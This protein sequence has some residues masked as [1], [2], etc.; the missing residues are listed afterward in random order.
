MS[1]RTGFPP[2]RYRLLFFASLLA[3]THVPTLAR[4]PYPNCSSPG[5]FTVNDTDIK[6]QT[7]RNDLFRILS[8]KA[9]ISWFYNT[10]VGGDNDHQLYGNFLCLGHFS[11]VKCQ[12]CVTRAAQNIDKPCRKSK[13]AIV[14]E[15]DCQLRYSDE[16]FFG[17]VGD[18]A[19]NLPLFNKRNASNPALFRLAVKTLMRIPTEEAAFGLSTTNMLAIGHSNNYSSIDTMHGLAQCTTDLSAHSCNRCLQIALKQILDCCYF[20]RGARVYSYF[21]RGARVYSKSCFLRYELYDFLGITTDGPNSPPSKRSRRNASVAV[22]VAIPVVGIVILGIC[23]CY[24]GSR[25]TKHKEILPY[26]TPSGT[27]RET[28][29]LYRNI[30]G[31]NQMK[32][33]EFPL[34]SFHHILT[35]TNNFSE[36]NKL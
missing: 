27:S 4:P 1:S 20:R 24:L 13:Q 7:L 12:D 15:E 19:S 26:T 16:P 34:I 33:Q 23:L 21:R 22:F 5:N 6:F 36:S 3:L 28:E 30:Q 25:N 14:W 2:I 11:P 35:A 18:A 10:T 29:L 8:S 9:S 32:P 17:T 31:K